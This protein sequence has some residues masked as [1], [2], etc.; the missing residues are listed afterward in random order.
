M[1]LFILPWKSGT[2]SCGKALELLGYRGLGHSPEVF[3]DKEY[4]LIDSAN[5]VFYTFQ[6]FLDIPT[7]IKIYIRS[8]LSFIYELG[9]K[10][11]FFDDFP[12]GHQFIDPMILKT[13]FEDA[14]F[15][16]LLRNDDD[17]LN[18][19]V[20]H[21]L[22]NATGENIKHTLWRRDGIHDYYLLFE[23]KLIKKGIL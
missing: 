3:N 21:D 22:C 13:I 18:S 8:K 17:W 15:I 10:Y 23:K 16:Y 9:Q 14:K 19:V 1:K 2:T 6:S 4:E 12:M 20:N 5:K 7:E 11:D